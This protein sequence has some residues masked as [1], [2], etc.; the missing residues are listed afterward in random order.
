ME[1]TETPR[2]RREENML[3]W[4]INRLEMSVDWIHL[5]TNSDVKISYEHGNELS[6]SI[7]EENSC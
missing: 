5:A 1:P 2:C 3:K 4:V 7:N 6:D